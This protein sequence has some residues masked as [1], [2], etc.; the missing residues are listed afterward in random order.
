MGR[1]GERPETYATEAKEFLRQRLIGGWLGAWHGLGGCGQCMT[2][3]RHGKSM[4]L[5]QHLTSGAGG[6]LVV[7]AVEASLQAQ[8][9]AR[10]AR[11]AHAMKS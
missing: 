4:T 3:A 7:G 8:Q 10:A 5:W 9:T 1:K 2:L 6:W 11:P